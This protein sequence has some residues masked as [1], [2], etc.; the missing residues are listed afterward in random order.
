[1]NKT[2][3]LLLIAL[4]VASCAFS[5]SEYLGYQENCIDMQSEKLDSILKE[6]LGSKRYMQ[7][8]DLHQT[9]FENRLLIAIDIDSNGTVTNVFIRDEKN[10]LLQNENEN[11]VNN[12]SASSFNICLCEYEHKGLSKKDFFGT[13]ETTQYFVFL[14]SWKASF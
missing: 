9:N 14:P 2:I 4:S 1:M 11:L 5:Q 3:L 12:I 7:L 10:F 6:T 13:K 8:Y